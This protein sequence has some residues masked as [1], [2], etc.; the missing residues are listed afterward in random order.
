M[1]AA[2]GTRLDRRAGRRE[3]AGLHPHRLRPLECGEVEAA[4]FVGDERTVRLVGRRVLADRGVAAGPGDRIGLREWSSGRAVG[5][6]L[7]QLTGDLLVELADLRFQLLDVF[8]DPGLASLAQLLLAQGQVADRLVGEGVGGAHRVFRVLLLRREAQGA[9][10]GVVLDGE[11][12]GERRRRALV[13]ELLGDQPWDLTGRGEHGDLGERDG[14]DQRLATELKLSLGHEQRVRRRVRAPDRLGL[15]V[16]GDEGER[17]AD[18]RA[19]GDDRPPPDQHS[20]VLDWLH[21]GPVCRRSKLPG[22]VPAGPSTTS[23]ASPPPNAAQFGSSSL[24]GT[25]FSGRGTD[26]AVHGRR[27]DLPARGEDDPG[28]VHGLGGVTCP[29]RGEA[30]TAQRLRHVDCGPRR[31]RRRSGHA[32]RSRRVA[33]EGSAW[34]WRWRARAQQVMAMRPSSA[35]R[36]RW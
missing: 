33:R 8:Q 30:G 16:R 25:T 20:D 3:P 7:G 28:G 22:H 10:L 19:D 29:A 17:R 9:R 18:E 34:S 15:R 36:P 35:W 1:P 31:G 32:R 21:H 11:L 5:V 14:A 27:L 26:D 24:A 23:T 12:G 6:Q 4:A 2:I 13:A